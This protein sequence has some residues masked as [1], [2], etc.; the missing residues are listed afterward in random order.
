MNCYKIF[1]MVRKLGKVKGM[2][3]GIVGVG[4]ENI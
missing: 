3:L 4:D 1:G 2:G